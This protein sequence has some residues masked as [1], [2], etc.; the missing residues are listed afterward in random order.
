MSLK[1]NVIRINDRVRIINPETFVR[2]GYPWS[3]EYVKE[4]VIT[5]EQRQAI[6]NLLYPDA[7]PACPVLFKFGEEESVEELKMIDILAYV[8]L[9]KNGYGGKERTVHTK[10]REEL[11]GK[12]GVVCDRK[13]VKTGCYHPG[14]SSQGYYDAY[15][16]YEPAYLT[17]EKSHVILRILVHGINDAFVTDPDNQ[18]WIENKHLEKITIEQLDD[19]WK[20][21]QTEMSALNLDILSRF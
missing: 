19:E 10:L 8:I 21:K 13:V 14:Y 20:P 7:A 18:I 16:E 4:N 11:R 5:K 2:C 1:K 9:M 17:N 3:K 12:T 15:P 6:R